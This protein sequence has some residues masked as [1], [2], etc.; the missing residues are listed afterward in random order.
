MVG[1]ADAAFAR[2]SFAKDQE[3]RCWLIVAP[4]VVLTVVF[5][6][7]YNTAEPRIRSGRAGG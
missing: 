6:S 3:R 1:S 4:F 7:G 2:G 5:A